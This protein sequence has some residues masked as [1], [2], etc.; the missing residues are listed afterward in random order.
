MEIWE[1]G[2]LGRRRFGKKTLCVIYALLAAHSTA[3]FVWPHHPFLFIVPRPRES[4]LVTQD[5]NAES[6]ATNAAESPADGGHSSPQPE[7]TQITELESLNLHPMVDRKE[8]SIY[9]PI[10]LVKEADPCNQKVTPSTL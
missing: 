10:H 5:Y 8:Q 2:D 6:F 9:S 3:N 4:S 1:D 7:S